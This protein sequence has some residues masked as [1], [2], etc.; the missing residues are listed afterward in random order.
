[1]LLTTPG[2]QRLDATS[3]ELASV[4]VVVIAPVGEQPI[5]A[6]A[7]AA[8]LAGDR[9]D[10]IDQRQELGDVIAVPT[11]QGDRQR[12]PAGVGQQVVL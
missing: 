12:Q 4:L 7:R 9:H 11:G 8:D 2:D 3:P 5:G 10:A 6:L 1:V